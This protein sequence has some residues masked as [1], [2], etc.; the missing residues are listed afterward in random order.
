M[1]LDDT[2][3][4]SFDAVVLRASIAQPPVT[5]DEI[6]SALRMIRRGLVEV[7]CRGKW[8]DAAALHDVA[9][10]IRERRNR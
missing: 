10:M 8:I 9:L 3:L 6:E 5:G 7:V 2:K 1:E 4:G